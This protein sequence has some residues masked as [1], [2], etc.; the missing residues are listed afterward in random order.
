MIAIGLLFVRMLCDYFK[1]RPQLEAEIVILRHQL[2]L[3]Q[4]R[5][6]RRPHLRWV[7][8]A[9]FIWLYR[10]C[11]RV[12][13]AITIVRPETILRWHRMG[14]AAY[15]RWKSRSSGGRPRIAREVRD[16]IRRMSFD[17]PLWGAPKIHGVGSIRRECTDHLIVFN[18]EH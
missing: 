3:L 13:R 17:N 15:W 10:R 8:R 6:P 11:P 9:P 4:R 2:N 5:A 14:F 12:L 1:S 18:A 7:D 16:L